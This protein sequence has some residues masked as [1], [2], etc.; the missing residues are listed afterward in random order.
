MF[1]IVN[2]GLLYILQVF[3]NDGKY[4]CTEAYMQNYTKPYT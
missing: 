1:L 2:S 3:R 4:W